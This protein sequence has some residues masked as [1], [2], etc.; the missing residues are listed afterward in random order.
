MQQLEL[1]EGLFGGWLRLLVAL[2]GAVAAGQLIAWVALTVATR[3]ARR[4]EVTWDDALV[5]ALHGPARVILS[6]VLVWPASKLVDAGLEPRTGLGRLVSVSM[7]LAVGWL[8]QRLVRVATQVMEDRA[9]RAANGEKDAELKLRGLRTQI[10]VLRRITNIG[11]GALA[12]ALAMLQFD[13]VRTVGLSLLASAGV[14]GVVLGLA[15]QR[16]MGALLAGIQL[17]I[18]QPVRIGDTVIVENEWG[19]IE[20]I[21]LTYV[22]VRVWDQRRLI[23]PMTRF[24]EQ[25][26]QNWT[27]VSRELLGTIFVYCDHRVPLDAMRAELT[28]IVKDNPAWDGRVCNLVVTDVKERVL[29]VRAL[30]SAAN[31]DDQWNLRCL[32]R[33]KLVV[34]L[35]GLEGGRYLP[36]TRFEGEP[37]G[38]APRAP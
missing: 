12:C 28:R 8:A 5:A 25:P 38:D 16:P 2:A 4:T 9:V 10:L 17:S 37:H 20:E 22:V 1:A 26:F 32:V 33:E 30:I 15:A 24:L 13:E 14:A 11:L 19:T 3:L 7:I 23:V 18:T 34:W 29:E 35:A 31:A 6:A 36:R 27:K 21:N